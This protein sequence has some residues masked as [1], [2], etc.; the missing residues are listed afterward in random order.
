MPRKKV[1][2]KKLR[3][4]KKKS[5]GMIDKEELLDIIHDEKWAILQP[6]I[7]LVNAQVKIEELEEQID[8]PDYYDDRGNNYSP[9]FHGQLEEAQLKSDNAEKMIAELDSVTAFFMGIVITMSS[10]ATVAFVLLMIT[11]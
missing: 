11:L 4:S 1:G 7:D 10:I 6:K 5:V 3:S 2:V 8:N 9:T